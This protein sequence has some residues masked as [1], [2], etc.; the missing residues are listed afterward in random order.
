MGG[1]TSKR[2]VTIR[3]VAERAQVS[4]STVSH[5]FSGVRPISRATRDRVFSAAAELGYDANPSAR[6]LRTGRSGLVGL[7]L[8]PRYA[9]AHTRDRAETF[10]RLVGSVATEM[11]RRKVGLIHVPALDDPAVASVPMDGC[12]VAHPYGG[13][14][15]VSELLRRNVP[16]VTIEEDPERPDLPWAVRLDYTT[17]VTGLLDH[18][19]HQG[20][21]RIVLL[22]GSEDNA[23]NRRTRE[24]HRD[25]CERNGQRARTELLSESLSAGS[26]A[27]RVRRLL[28]AARRPD[29]VVVATS[30]FAAVVAGVAG[31]LGLR[32]PE[33]LMIAALTDSEH[34]RLA[35]PPI[36]AMDL[37]HE[38]LAAAGVELMLA[39]LA[40]AATPH[41]PV[42]V[43][44]ELRFRAS[45][46]RIDG[47]P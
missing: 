37:S 35:T 9:V 36:T 5:A 31:D 33:D 41:A 2:S 38:Q 1:R 28:T 23:W 43:D 32:V 42:V 27:T 19:H 26:A 29:A 21:G 24:T 14:S 20:A 22:T 11:L 17:A 44:P 18:L 12:I 4:I 25:W 39:R 8:R 16:L 47:S 3:D 30:D 7:V 34:S 6:S 13:D 15:V 10:N 46:R 40:G 45:T